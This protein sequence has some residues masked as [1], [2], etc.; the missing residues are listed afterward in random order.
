MVD[1][2]RPGQNYKVRKAVNSIPQA[3]SLIYSHPASMDT[4]SSVPRVTI[5]QL[6]LLNNV[7]T[8]YNMISLWSYPNLVN[9]QSVC[10]KGVL[11]VCIIYKSSYII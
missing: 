8:L 1:C 4:H 10:H 11:C 6:I 9:E 2:R 7:I 3:A 5:W